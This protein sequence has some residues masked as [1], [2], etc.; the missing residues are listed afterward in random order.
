[1]SFLQAAVEAP[2]RKL[3]RRKR[4]ATPPIRVW[5]EHAHGIEGVADELHRHL[6]VTIVRDHDGEVIAIPEPVGNELSSQIDIGSLLLLY[7]DRAQPD[8]SLLPVLGRMLKQPDRGSSGEMAVIDRDF[9]KSPQGPEVLL[10]ASLW[11]GFSG[12]SLTF[13]VKYLTSTKIWRFVRKLSLRA[14]TSSQR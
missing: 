3:V 5:I 13:A 12:V 2:S 10:L 4:V 8:V 14:S 1:M 9:R 11:P 7:P 6:E